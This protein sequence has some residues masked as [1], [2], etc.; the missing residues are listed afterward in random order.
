MVGSSTSGRIACGIGGL[1]A[2]LSACMRPALEEETETASS[3]QSVS[4]CAAGPRPTSGVKLER[5]FADATFEA[6]LAMVQAPGNAQR[7]YVV[8]KGGKVKVTSGTGAGTTTFV[9]L[10]SRVNAAPMEAGLLGMAFHPRFADN[11]QVFFFYTK[12]EAQSPANVRTVIARGRSTDGGLTIAPSSITELLSF[13]PASQWALGGHLA[14]GKDGLLYVGT[15]CGSNTD[16]QNLAESPQSLAGK[17]LRIDVDHGSP[18]AIPPSNPY[19]NGG[20]RPEIFA[21]G[22]RNPWRWSFDRVTGDLWLGDVGVSRS[23]EI[24]KVVLGGDYGWSRREGT[25]CATPP[26]PA[27]TIDPIVEISHSESNAVVGG[28]VYRGTELPALEGRYVYGDYGSGRIWSIATD[29]ASPTPKLLLDT[30]LTMPS[31]AE[32]AD[33]ELYAL[34]IV[35]GTVHRIVA[36]PTAGSI[37]EKLSQTGCMSATDVTQPGPK[38]VPYDVV[39]PL[40][41]DGAD[42]ERWL[43]LPSGGK[44]KVQPDGDWEL[45]IGTVL[46]KTFSLAGK[47]VETR[48]FVRHVDGGWAGY[49]YE[50]DD[51]GTDATLLAGGK[52][53]TVGSQTWTFPSRGQCLTCHNAATR[54]A[55]G[56]ET[57]QLNRPLTYPNGVTE[58]QLAHLEALGVFSATAPL[59]ASRP[60][61][62]SPTDPTRTAEERARSY[63]HA[64][65]SFCHRP[66]GSGQGSMDLRFATSP[67]LAN[68]C[69]A[70]P[71]QGTLGIANAAIVE[72]GSPQSSV[73][74]VR[75]KSTGPTRMP[76]IGS[77][78]V[79]PL[80]TSL[81]DAWIGSIATCP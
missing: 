47:R 62:P 60:S 2:L 14:F 6:P 1:F 12:P 35:Q 46:V 61:L 30:G 33:G 49:S 45:P 21:R 50:W 25:F 69:G 23:E 8:E 74:A 43:A 19:A 65:C 80:G 11:G 18:Y 31:L 78:L 63:L 53:K 39:S 36:A 15:G 4:A 70:N 40:W 57:A 48:L 7:F 13:I 10:T 59:P 68:V 41:S 75:M 20:G 81:V 73:L 27:G 17:M 54:G 16:P 3:Q 71:S 32:G 28:Y 5:V 72:P 56:L 44:I 76:P 9:D 26:C 42:K 67:A 22:F 34:D 37:P 29:T 77:A 64:N 66:G 24:D 52:T 38:L 51:L 55:I 58:N 79:D